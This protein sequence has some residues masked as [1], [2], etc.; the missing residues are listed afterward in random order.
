MTTHQWIEDMLEVLTHIQR[1]ERQQGGRAAAE[2]RVEATHIVA[3]R[4]GRA[5]DTVANACLRQLGFKA[6][7]FERAVEAWLTGQPGKLRDRTRLRAQRGEDRRRIDEFFGYP[8]GEGA[9]EQLA[10]PGL[11]TRR[12]PGGA[13]RGPAPIVLDK[14]VAKVFPDSEAVNAALKL[15]IRAARKAQARRPASG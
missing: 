3:T 12:P 4:R 1:L 6:R 14:D 9:D 11:P 7:E 13:R 10:M 5:Y 8:A 2:L 15:L